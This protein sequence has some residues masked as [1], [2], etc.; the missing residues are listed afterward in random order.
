MFMSKDKKL[1][2]AI[3]A[4]AIVFLCWSCGQSSLVRIHPGS[5]S[6]MAHRF[7][8]AFRRKV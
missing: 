8:P 2:L 6:Q 7:R 1:P 4:A 3:C 5:A